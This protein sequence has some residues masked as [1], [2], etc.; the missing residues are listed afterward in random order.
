MKKIFTLLTVLVIGLQLQAKEGMWLPHLIA[1]LNYSDMQRMGLQ[2]SAEEIYA[3]NK[4]SLKDAVV[5]FNGGCTGELI[6]SQGLLLTNHHCGYSQIQ[7]HSTKEN[8]YLEDG[9]WA[10][11]RS[12][13]LPNS[14]LYAAIIREIKDVSNEILEGSTPEMSEEERDSIIKVNAQNLLGEAQAKNPGLEF[15]LKDFFFGNQFLL[16]SKVKYTDVRLVGAPPSSIGKYGKDTDNWVWPRHTGDFSMFRVYANADNQP[17]EYSETNVPYKPAQHLKINI[18]GVKEGDFTMVYGFPGSTNQYLPASEVAN[19]VNEYNPFR[20]RIRDQIINILD[21][22][23]RVDEDARLQYASKFARSSNSWKRWKG[24]ILGIKRTNAL[25]VLRQEEKLF[26]QMCE[27]IPE[28]KDDKDLVAKMDALYAKRIPLTKERF[29]YIEVGYFGIEAFRH[30]LNY[31][32][33]IK[34]AEAEDEEALKTEADR[35]AKRMEGF[36]KDYDYDLD[37]QVAINILPIYLETIKTNP[38]EEVRELQEEGSDNW[39]EEIAE[40]YEDAPFFKEDFAEELKKN[41]AKM[42]KKIAE[43]DLY[44]LSLE[45]YS[46]YFEVINAGL[47]PINLEIDALQARYVK[48]LQRAFP[49]KSFYPDANSTLRVAYGQV[50]SYE[51]RD[52]VKYEAQTYLKGVMEKYVPGDYEFDLPQKLIDLYEAKDYGPY[53][54]NGKMPVCFVATNHTTGG[55]S[56]SPVLNARGELIGLNFDRAWDGVMSDMYFDP[57]ICRNVMVDLRYV[58][59]IIDK[60]GGASYLV[61]EMD[62]VRHHPDE[63]VTK[64]VESEE[65]SSVKTKAADKTKAEPVMEVQ[66]REN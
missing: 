10:A 1:Q 58:L 17:A 38:G 19:T 50:K 29:A 56:G 8:N 15:E 66:Y 43:S 6:S 31:S 25:E 34:H 22:K 30:V 20:I 27:A 41:P 60:L 62:L 5:H 14:G 54:E 45:M 52:A 24:E 26:K 28:L 65:K 2:I 37:K 59:F 4:S 40:M 47:K 23:M 48:A 64:K 18:A 33:L 16:I 51:A 49:K 13:E 36:L 55:N 11:S 7:S 21:A 12:E 32:N 61:E 46:H 3:V 63:T 9:F 39:P 53:G 35:L 44:E 42:A 57:S